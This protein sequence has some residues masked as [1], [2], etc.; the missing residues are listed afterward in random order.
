MCFISKNTYVR[1]LK[2]KFMLIL[3]CPLEQAT[4]ENYFHSSYRKGYEGVLAKCFAHS[5][6]MISA[7]FTLMPSSKSSYVIKHC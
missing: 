2:Y 3:H 5:S 1:K 6:G 4:V 7:E